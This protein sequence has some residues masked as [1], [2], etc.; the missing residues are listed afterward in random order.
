MAV[1]V[2]ATSVVSNNKLTFAAA[3]KPNDIALNSPISGLAGYSARHEW[4]HRDNYDHAANVRT[5]P[6]ARST[7]RLLRLSLTP[8]IPYRPAETWPL[9]KSRSK[10][11]R[12]RSIPFLGRLSTPMATCSRRPRRAVY[13]IQRSQNHGRR[14]QLLRTLSFR[15]TGSGRTV[16][17]LL[18]KKVRR[19]IHK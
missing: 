8:A 2:M 3:G 4:N 18:R 12:P 1:L 14:R 16:S 7:R 5:A 19:K 17:R 6:I 13:T 9:R 15:S 10:M 11:R